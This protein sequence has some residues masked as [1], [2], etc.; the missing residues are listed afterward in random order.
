MQQQ[1][2]MQW[3]RSCGNWVTLSL[4]LSVLRPCLLH[5]H[6]T[7]RK[8]QKPKSLPGVWSELSGSTVI[9]RSHVILVTGGRAACSHASTAWARSV[10]RSLPP[11]LLSLMA[12]YPPGHPR[13]PRHVLD[14]FGSPSQLRLRQKLLVLAL[15]EMECVELGLCPSVLL[16]TT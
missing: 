3:G 10:S 16:C 12:A 13:A 1:T 7:M 4:W 6:W 15:W 14:D 5:T 9:Q 8:F 11:A 2:T